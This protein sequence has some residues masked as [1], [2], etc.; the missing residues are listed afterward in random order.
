MNIASLVD[1][2]Y[3]NYYNDEEVY[4]SYVLTDEEKRAVEAVV[5]SVEPEEFDSGEFDYSY[6]CT[7]YECSEDLIFNQQAF[8]IAYTD[9]GY[10]IVI[11]KGGVTNAYVVPIELSA[12]FDNIMAAYF[13]DG[14]VEEFYEEEL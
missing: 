4:G 7:V 1:Y 3:Y 8:D 10:A 11:T 6:Y 12:I 9:Y 14:Y 13:E 5:A 2:N